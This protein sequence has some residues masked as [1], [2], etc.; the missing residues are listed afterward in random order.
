MT[1][2][3]A[4]ESKQNNLTVVYKQGVSFSNTSIDINATRDLAKDMDIIVLTVGEE[5]YT[6]TPGNINNLF[7]NKEQY[8]LADA[9]FALKKP[10]VLVYLGGK[11]KNKKNED[12]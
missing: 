10:V 1:V 9:L 8:E 4:I 6:E 7:L 11:N 3:K 12:L 2:F 5:T